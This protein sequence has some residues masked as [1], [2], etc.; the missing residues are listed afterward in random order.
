MNKDTKQLVFKVPTAADAR[1]GRHTSV[2]T[3]AVINVQG[4][5]VQHT[6]GPGEL[7]IDKPL[8]PKVDA[9]KPMPAPMPAPMPTPAAAEAPKPKPLS[10]LEK[11]R[12]EKQQAG[13]K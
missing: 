12:L 8:P 3:T 7:R 5:P 1:E 11:L 9:P 13:E 10:R 4:E 6:L 2:L